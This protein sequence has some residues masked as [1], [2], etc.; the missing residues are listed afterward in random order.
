[1]GIALWFFRTKL[2]STGHKSVK[3][4][5]I[6]QIREHFKIF[7]AN[8]PDSSGIRFRWCLII[9]EDALQSLIQYP[10]PREPSALSGGIEENRAWVTVVDPKYNLDS[11]LSV[12]RQETIISRIYAILS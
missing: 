7:A 4:G 1:M 12:Q 8:D 3:F 6:S 11:Y 9:D 5:E 2:V 10:K